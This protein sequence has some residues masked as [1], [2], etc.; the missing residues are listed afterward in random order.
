MRGAEEPLVQE[1]L[2]VGERD[3]S[4]DVHAD[5]PSYFL[6]VSQMAL[7]PPSHSPIL[8]HPPQNWSFWAWQVEIKMSSQWDTQSY[9][10]VRYVQSKGPR[11]Y[12]LRQE[13]CHQSKA[14]LGYIVEGLTKTKIKSK[15]MNWEI[16]WRP[17][18]SCSEG[19]PW[20]LQGLELD[21]ELACT[22]CFWSY[23]KRG[24]WRF[25]VT[26]QL[27]HWHLYKQTNALGKYKEE[28][29]GV[30]EV[31]SLTW[32]LLD[33]SMQPVCHAIGTQ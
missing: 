32:R 4:E 5:R 7:P 2:R 10:Y 26:R 15:Y 8:P 9:S 16:Q 33:L 6:K 17:Q 20:M 28:A 12:L 31:I 18:L 25:S 23:Q 19:I 24:R 14:S 3:H 1:Y 21:G 27:W 30:S 13:D 22:G 11:V 29:D